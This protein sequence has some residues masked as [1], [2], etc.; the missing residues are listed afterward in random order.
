M[1]IYIRPILVSIGVGT[2][3]PAPHHRLEICPHLHPCPE[4]PLPV[5]HGDLNPHGYLR[6]YAKKLKKEKK[7]KIIH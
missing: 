1:Y 2:L 5:P 4:S 7:R 3:P 6:V